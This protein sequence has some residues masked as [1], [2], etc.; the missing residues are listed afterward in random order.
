MSNAPPNYPTRWRSSTT[1][2]PTRSAYKLGARLCA[3]GPQ[4]FPSGQEVLARH[5]IPSER[6]LFFTTYAMGTATSRRRRGVPRNPPT[7]STAGSSPPPRSGRRGAR[8]S[9]PTT[10]RK[11]RTFRIHRRPTTGT[12]GAPA[13]VLKSSDD[14][15]NA[16]PY[17]TLH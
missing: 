4:N 7:C 11:R 3:R 1:T 10:S 16:R 2:A 6:A 8:E 5:H 12:S 14:A 13:A 15:T 17:R 9:T